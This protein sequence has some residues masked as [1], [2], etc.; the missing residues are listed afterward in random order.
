MIKR[1]ICILNAVLLVLSM[2]VFADEAENPNA[3]YESNK[4]EIDF[5]VAA[6]FAEGKDESNY[7]REMTAKDFRAIL[8]NIGISD[9]Y[10]REIDAFGIDYTAKSGVKR[11]EAA[12]PLVKLIGYDSQAISEGGFPTGYLNVAEELGFFKGVS[13]KGEENLSVADAYRTIYNALDAPFFPEV[14]IP[15]KKYYIDDSL[16]YLTE[17]LSIYKLKGIVTSTER[18][19]MAGFSAA[20]SGQLGIGDM[21]VYT[22]GGNYEEFFAQKIEAFCR[23]DKDDDEYTLISIKAHSRNTVTK[24]AAQDIVSYENYQYTYDD[25]QK[26]KLQ[27]KKLPADCAIVYNC[28]GITRDNADMLNMLPENGSVTFVDNDGDGETNVLII[29]DYDIL[30]VDSVN[31]SGEYIVTKKI[32]TQNSQKLDVKNMDFYS[33]SGDKI[34]YSSLAEW[35]VLNLAKDGK[36]GW[37]YCVVSTDSKSGTVSF[38]DAKNGYISLELADKN[39]MCIAKGLLQDM[40][41]AKKLFNYQTSYIYYFTADGNV[42][43]YKMLADS[44]FRVAYLADVRICDDDEGEEALRIKLY[45]VENAGGLTLFCSDK[46]KFEGERTGFAE[47]AAKMKGAD[48]YALDTLFR[49]K[50]NAD[51]EISD[52]DMP[53]DNGDSLEPTGKSGIVKVYNAPTVNFTNG[54]RRGVWPRTESGV[55]VVLD[56]SVGGRSWIEACPISATNT[57]LYVPENRADFDR[58]VIM[59]SWN[60]SQVVAE[61][62]R[63]EGETIL[64]TLLVELAGNGVPK[65]SESSDFVNNK[66]L[67]SSS[68]QY[69]LVKKVITGLDENDELQYTLQL[70]GYKGEAEYAAENAELVTQLKIIEGSVIRIALNGSDEIVAAD[71][72][73]NADKLKPGSSWYSYSGALGNGRGVFGLAYKKYEDAVAVSLKDPRDGVLWNDIMYVNPKMVKTFVYDAKKKTVRNGDLSDI[74]VYSPDGY[75]NASRIFYYSETGGGRA[76]F[77]FNGL[78]N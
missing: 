76:I 65:R 25:T 43:A 51:G 35:N 41:S 57:H 22:N 62:Y 14:R 72:V 47:I 52:I 71:V 34:E 75:D 39:E 59:N 2:S 30:S 13:A 36:G 58:Y 10:L 5:L 66:N 37:L 73:V 16:T 55:L 64:P 50:T 46:C 3:A 15:G 7:G 28:I 63:I 4:N 56:E 9:E 42:G 53:F 78:E 31:S 48:G 70:C 24:V 44:N 26:D 38:V 67:I 12:A 23:Y 32:G 49:Y 21:Y 68:A 20:V 77:V 19:N 74:N 54:R 17:K 40:D 29:N 69:Y 6:G 1:I 27:K 8:K 18:S 60:D 33:V 11:I 61:A 45:D